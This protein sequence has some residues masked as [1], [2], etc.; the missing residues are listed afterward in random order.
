MTI[1]TMA[2]VL[3]LALATAGLVA[4]AG[5]A[6]PHE[7]DDAG[8]LL[9]AISSELPRTR[10]ASRVHYC[11]RWPSRCNVTGSCLVSGGCQP[12]IWACCSPGL[13]CWAV[14]V[15]D[16]CPDTA[17]LY[18]FDCIAGESAVDPATGEA[19]IVCHD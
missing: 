12:M 8:R 7:A 11:E 3:T 16:A 1:P 19:I 4:L 9:A 13:G 17:D 15:A 5:A 14:G 18:P 6:S 2:K 10:P